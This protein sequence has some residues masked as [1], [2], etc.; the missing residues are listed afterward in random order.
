[1]RYGLTRNALCCETMA[2][3]A[4]K[5]SFVRFR[6]AS[7]PVPCDGRELCPLLAAAAHNERIAFCNNN[8]E[9]EVHS[10]SVGALSSSSGKGG[11]PPLPHSI[12]TLLCRMA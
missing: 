10:R 7:A 1:V 5:T 8:K 9:K 3:K 12:I 2:H 4:R 11:R 6:L